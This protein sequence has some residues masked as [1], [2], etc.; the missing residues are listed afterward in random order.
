MSSTPT[1][2]VSLRR[3]RSTKN[4]DVTGSPVSKKSSPLREDKCDEDSVN[5]T[6]SQI[7]TSRRIRSQPVSS[8]HDSYS[9]T[10]NDDQS[11]HST[12]EEKNFHTPHSS[13]QQREI[14]H[15]R[16]HSPDTPFICSQLGGT[17]ECEV[18]WDCNSPGYSKDDLK[19]MPGGE[20]E[21]GA[22]PVT[23]IAPVPHRVLFPKGK[24]RPQTSTSVKS[25]TAQLDKLLDQLRSKKND[26]GES[27]DF[28]S[29]QPLLKGSQKNQVEDSSSLT[30]E[31][32]SPTITSSLPDLLKGASSQPFDLRADSCGNE[33]QHVA[34]TSEAVNII[35]ELN[36]SLFKGDVLN[37]GICDSSVMNLV[38]DINVR[39]S[40]RK[41]SSVGSDEGTKANVANADMFDDDL[42][43][44]SVIRTTQ[45]MEEALTDI[46]SVSLVTNVSE[47][48]DITE[49]KQSGENLERCNNLDISA[50]KSLSVGRVSEVQNISL[51]KASEV[52][53]GRTSDRHANS[54]IQTIHKSTG[55]NQNIRTIHNSACTT[56]MNMV[57]TQVLS[58]N[59]KDCDSGFSRT[60]SNDMNKMK[61]YS[62]CN[63]NDN[64]YGDESSCSP[65]LGNPHTSPTDV[66]PQRRIRNSFRLGSIASN[67]QKNVLSD[68][69]R[70]GSGPLCISSSKFVSNIHENEKC[71]IVCSEMSKN[72]KNDGLVEFENLNP[73]LEECRTK[74]TYSSTKSSMIFSV[75]ENEVA[76]LPKASRFQSQKTD[77][78]DHDSLSTEVPSG[79]SLFRNSI[80]N[81]QLGK[82][83]VRAQTMRGPLLRSHS[84][85]N[86]KVS[87]IGVSS[88]VRRSN[89]SLDV[90]VSREFEEDD[91]FFESLLSN[92]PEYEEQSLDKSKFQPEAHLLECNK[93]ISPH[94]EKCSENSI[95]LCESIVTHDKSSS[96]RG[97]HASSFST[98][99]ANTQDQDNMIISSEPAGQMVNG[100]HLERAFIQSKSNVGH[101]KNQKNLR[102]RTVKLPILLMDTSH[103][104]KQEESDLEDHK[105]ICIR[106]SAPRHLQTNDILDDDL[107]EDDVL[108]LLDEVES[109]YG[110]QQTHPEMSSSQSSYFQQLRCTQD[111][112]ARKKEA[113]QR[114]RQEKQKQ[115]Q[116]KHHHSVC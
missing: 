23:F 17:Q 21:A 8:P 12:S 107:F 60:T 95:E 76:V 43:N 74:K 98:S 30:P 116:C 28:T 97:N 114:L 108:T 45:A 26:P 29:C 65:V 55:V 101:N 102:P 61:M 112:I 67:L 9:L 13:H 14:E 50:I 54:D 70:S 106:S 52:S 5:C 10:K 57:D 3:K 87:N 48:R 64:K 34:S 51:Q 42:F 27:E 66:P 18:V 104:V 93:N 82:I 72:T 20:G 25:T 96:R 7:Y 44:D 90:D 2:R 4:T 35:S 88:T 100:M 41:K 1:R 11:I 89:S 85:G 56:D 92:L 16:Q 86:A 38:S 36:D 113:A 84:T 40:L 77:H 73:V 33:E 39:Q 32:D 31:E 99:V 15:Q 59:F 109:Q 71:L 6:K 105:P 63:A 75:P 83:P 81:S 94:V 68:T 58:Q 37:M 24:G 22:I 47:V 110:S 78:F 79:K 53:S 46:D 111:E 62:N 19:R 91:E 80:F 69:C 49:S 103:D 115:R